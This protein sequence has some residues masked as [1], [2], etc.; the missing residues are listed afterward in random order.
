MRLLRQRADIEAA[1]A[2][3]TGTR[4]RRPE[5]ARRSL[6]ERERIARELHDVIAHDVA[7]MVVQAGA[8]ERLMPHATGRGGRE[9]DAHPGQRPQGDRRAAPA[10]GHAARA[11]PAARRGAG[12]AARCPTGG[13]AGPVGL[14]VSLQVTGSVRDVGDA[15]EV[16]AFRIVQEAL[17]NVLKYAAG[18]RTRVLVDYGRTRADHQRAGRRRRQRCSDRPCLVRGGADRH[19]GT[20]APVRRHPRR[21]PAARRR[22]GRYRRTARAGDRRVISVVIADDQALIRRRAAA[23]PGVRGRPAAWSPRP[24]T[25]RPAVAAA[26]GV[27]AG[28]RAD[29][30]A[31]AGHGRDRGH[32]VAATEPPRRWC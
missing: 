2:D 25:A 29:G 5:P 12:S 11:R 3:L 14:P 27:H 6:A 19:A 10:A 9:P 20:G 24:A 17:T 31:D 21:R 1:R 28:H 15:L 18:S 22:M 13:R 30:S 4:T 8:A 16:S 32:R 26:T 7:V 23:D